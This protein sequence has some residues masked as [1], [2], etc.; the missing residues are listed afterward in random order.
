MV[1]GAGSDETFGAGP[2]A[3]TYRLGPGNDIAGDTR[4]HDVYLGGSGFDLF[5]LGFIPP[6]G[7]DVFSGG[8]GFDAVQ[9]EDAGSVKNRS[10]RRSRER[11]SWQE[12]DPLD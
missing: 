10:R 4:G 9:Y 11:R 1:A 7:A 6:G 3:D 12:D 5:T 2:G 8:A